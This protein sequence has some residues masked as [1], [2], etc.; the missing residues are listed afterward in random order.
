MAVVSDDVRAV[1]AATVAGVWK[2]TDAD[3]AIYWLVVT[4]VGTSGPMTF[5]FEKDDL[6]DSFYKE[7]VDAMNTSS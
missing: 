2:V 3:S 7:L 6:R 1:N 4:C 5:R